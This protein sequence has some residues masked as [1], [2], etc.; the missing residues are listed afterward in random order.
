[1]SNFLLKNPDCVLIHIP[2]TGGTSIRKGAWNRRVR[3]P[4]FGSVPDEWRGYFKFAFVREPLDRFLSAYRMFTRGTE[5]DPDWALPGDAR[6]LSLDEFLDITRDESIVHDE[7]RS[8]FEEKIRHHTIPQTHPF[9]CLREADFIGRF[10]DIDADFARIA[11]HVG[12]RSALPRMHVTTDA[13][14]DPRAVLGDRLADALTRYYA[15]DI[16]FIEREL[17]RYRRLP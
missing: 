5:G 13:P 14:V 4:R 15:E 9:N 6:P 11:R 8:S 10:E 12:L 16:A 3:G 17:P 1:M 2:K 7:R